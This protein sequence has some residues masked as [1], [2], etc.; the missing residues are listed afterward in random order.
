M[1]NTLQ[2]VIKNNAK[3][4]W[5]V[6]AEAK[7]QTKAYLEWLGD[8]NFT[9]MGYRYYDVKAIEGDHRWIPQNDTSL[10][11]LKN[12]VNDRE[13]LLSRLPASARAEALSKNPLILTKTNSRARVHR[14]AYMDYVGVKVFNKEG[15]VVGEHRFLGLYS[16][17]FYNNSVTQL[18][19]L[20]EKIKRICEL[21]G[22][23]PGTHAYKAFANI[24][25]TYPRDEL[26]QTP[27]EELAQIVMGIFQMQ[28]RG[29]SR[30][31]I[32]KDI[33]GRVFSR[34][35]CLCQESAIT[36]SY[37]KKPKRYL[38]RHWAQ[39]KKWNLLRSSQSLYM[40]VRITL[41]ESTTTTRNSM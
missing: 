34:A 30:L 36:P 2:D 22:F 27:A 41:L 32:R 19:I 26:L 16:A 28:E 15:Q 24:I 10:G 6:S 40:P 12:S 13:R 23:E 31:F 7:K 37:A 14:P 8:H 17:S 39:L 33:F 11:L 20:R 29:I 38:K 9:M 25:E 21:S 4:N 3:F 1:T 35:W 18:P 5:P